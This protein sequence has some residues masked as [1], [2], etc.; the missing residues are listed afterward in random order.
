M[1]DNAPETPEQQHTEDAPQ[2][3]VPEAA[4]QP[5]MDLDSTIKVDGQEVSIK[6]LLASREET[7]RLKEY[8]DN[9]R[10]LVAPGSASDGQR[11]QAVRY[12]MS[13]EGYSPEDIDAYVSWTSNL[14]NQQEEPTANPYEEV[15]PEGPLTEEQQYYQ[16]EQ[17][18]IMAEQE[19]QR[20]SN[21]EDKQQRIGAEMMRKELDTAIEATVNS[22]DLIKKLLGVGGDEDASKREAIIRSEVE[23]AV[24]SNL[25]KRRASGEHF[26]KKWF[27]EEAGQAAQSV[28][29]KFRSVIG[30][31]DKIQRAPE[32]VAESEN[33]FTKKPVAP[34]SY[35]RGDDMGTLKDKVHDWT[36]DTLLRGAAEDAAGGKTKA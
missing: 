14:E 21:L 22:N 20:I 11:E 31:P 13:Q 12:L 3:A 33:L 34:P 7:A 10:I 17:A 26:D 16:Q 24:M 2:Q 19:Q 29:D 27:A 18:R 4:A 30:D 35:E 28:Y 6:D 25:R 8:A 36:L 9:A 5:A 23:S 1:T 15:P 32:T